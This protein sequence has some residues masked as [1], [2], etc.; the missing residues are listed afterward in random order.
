MHA[1]MDHNKT[2]PSR[3]SPISSYCAAEVRVVLECAPENASLK[4]L[5]L[6]V[7]V[8]VEKGWATKVQLTTLTHGVF[9]KAIVDYDSLPIGCRFYLSSTEHLT[10]GCKAIPTNQFGSNVWL[11]RSLVA[12]LGHYTLREASRRHSRVPTPGL[13]DPSSRDNPHP[14]RF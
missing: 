12:R 5:R 14:S 10:G 3:V 13:G 1:H 7:S 6:C 8:N 4:H 2:T 11:V 9:T